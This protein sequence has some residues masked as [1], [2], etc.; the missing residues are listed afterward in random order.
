MGKLEKRAT[1]RCCDGRDHVNAMINIDRTYLAKVQGEISYLWD[2]QSNRIM[3]CST[4]G[5][6]L[7]QIWVYICKHLVSR[8]HLFYHFDFFMKCWWVKTTAMYWELLK[9]NTCRMFQNNQEDDIQHF[10]WFIHFW[11]SWL[12]FQ[13]KHLTTGAS[14]VLRVIHPNWLKSIQL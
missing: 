2:Q 9:W 7:N 8:C 6:R 13:S 4:F 10:C 5:K 11:I 12:N 1:L 3:I 14:L